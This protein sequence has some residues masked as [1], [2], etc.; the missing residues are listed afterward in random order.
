MDIM[1]LGAIGELVGGVAVIGS[2]IYVG[3]QVRQNT[4]ALSSSTFHAVATS[5]SGITSSIAAESELSTFVEKGFFEPDDLTRGERLRL[6]FWWRG[7]FRLHENYH[8]Q[9]NQGFLD[10]EV[11]EGYLHSL[12]ANLGNPFV[13]DW[14]QTSKGSYGSQFRDLVERLLEDAESASAYTAI[15][16]DTKSES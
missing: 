6:G 5:I 14:W 8:Y 10:R 3:L 7:V 11:Y 4:K 16:E 15:A 1:E 12:T 2:L 9:A 13:R